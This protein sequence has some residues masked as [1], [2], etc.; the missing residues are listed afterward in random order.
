MFLMLVCG[1]VLG[2]SRLDAQDK[3]WPSEWGVEDQRGA[4]NRQT[5]DKVMEATKLIK[6]G[7]VYQLGK[8]YESGIP[9]DV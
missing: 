1:M 3:W 5:P 7:K 2:L 9:R 8:V 6:E 4:A